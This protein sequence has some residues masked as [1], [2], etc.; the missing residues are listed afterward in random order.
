[1]NNPSKE[2]GTRWESAVA[3]FLQSKG[4]PVWRM[5]QTGAQDEGDLGGL[6]SWAFE[7]RDRQKMDLSK[8]VRD[9]NSRAI[10]KGALYGVTIMKKRNS[11][12]GSAYVAMDL[13]TFAEILEIIEREGN[14]E[15]LK[16]TKRIN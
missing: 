12:V 10:A 7:C 9:A 16:T 11:A 14:H 3:K 15:T 13:E 5:A 2:K 8:N 4:F 6:P 1:M